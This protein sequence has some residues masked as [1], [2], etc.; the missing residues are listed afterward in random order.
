MIHREV[1]NISMAPM[2]PITG[3]PAVIL[4]A[5]IVAGGLAL[6]FYAMMRAR[7]FGGWAVVIALMGACSIFSLIL[8]CQP[9]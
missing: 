6:I 8:S 9:S 1:E 3:F 4:G 5:I 2:T 7:E